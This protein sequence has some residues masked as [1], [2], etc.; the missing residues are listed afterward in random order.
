MHSPHRSSATALTTGDSPDRHLPRTDLEAEQRDDGHTSQAPYLIWSGIVAVV[1]VGV[2][3][4]LFKR[5]FDRE[6]RAS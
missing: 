3:G 5:R 1:V 4:L 6:N 2:G